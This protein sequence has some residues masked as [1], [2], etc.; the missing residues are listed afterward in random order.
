MASFCSGVSSLVG[1]R[2]MVFKDLF[3]PM[4]CAFI[5]DIKKV[6]VGVWECTVGVWELNDGCQKKHPLSVGLYLSR[7]N[8]FNGGRTIELKSLKT[9]I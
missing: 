8:I 9:I 7:I 3:L 2:G 4:S 5:I 6:V 1:E